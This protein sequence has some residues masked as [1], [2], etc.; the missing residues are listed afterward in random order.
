MYILN[1][2]EK[3]KSYFKIQICY[4]GSD[5]KINLL[6][7]DPK[8]GFQRIVK[9]N[10]HSIILTSGTLSPL[11]SLPLELEVEFNKPLACPHIMSKE[12]VNGCVLTAG[13]NKVKLNFNF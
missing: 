3:S 8:V 9:M 11:N 5:I 12:Q 10:P 7:L 1:K 6:C 2:E 13:P 4:S